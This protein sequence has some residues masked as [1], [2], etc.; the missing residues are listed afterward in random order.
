MSTQ[1]KNQKK[2]LKFLKSGLDDVKNGKT[3]RIN[4]LWANLTKC[5]K[6]ESSQYDD[7]LKYSIS[8]TPKVTVL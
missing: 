7:L 6:N 2:L 1:K 3:H 4:T 5:K 8:V